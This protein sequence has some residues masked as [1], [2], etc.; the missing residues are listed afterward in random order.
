MLEEAKTTNTYESRDIDRAQEHVNRR[1]RHQTY[2]LKLQDR[3]QA[4]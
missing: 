1:E 4:S 2:L 3:A